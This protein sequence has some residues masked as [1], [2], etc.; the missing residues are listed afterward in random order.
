[1]IIINGW[2]TK[3]GGAEKHIFEVT[4]Y[5]KNNHEIYILL[6]KLAYIYSEKLKYSHKTLI[7]KYYIY[8]TIL[9]RDLENP[10]T[11]IILWLLRT[12][13]S[14]FFSPRDRFDIIVASSHL[15]CNI[16][17]AVFL[18]RKTGAKLVVYIYHLVSSRNELN[19]LADVI[20]FLREQFDLWLIKRNADVIF[21]ENTLVK[22]ELVKFGFDKDKIFITSDGVDL[23]FILNVTTCNKKKVYDACFVGRLV[24][25]KGVYDLIQIWKLVCQKKT[26]ALL[27]IIGDG[28]EF[29][30]LKKVIKNQYLERNIIL[31]GFVSE[32]EKFKVIKESRL[33][34]FPSYKEGWPL[35]ICEAMA[36]GVPVVAYDLPVYREVLN[37]AIQTV[38]YRDIFGFSKSI[39]EILNNDKLQKKMIL[40]GYEICKKYAWKKVANYE[41]NTIVSHLKLYK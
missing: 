8:S 4:Q 34:I 18:K 6:P 38:P 28:P 13:K 20:S 32:E 25:S 11:F 40:K 26:N 24:R 36:C 12:L 35:A 27:A 41:I 37:D 31:L 10:L 17:P 30:Y 3:I 39:L 14:M 7:G 5:W 29:Q 21:V 23:E 2:I 33:F 15:T 19:S 22:N 9:E 16:V 1:L